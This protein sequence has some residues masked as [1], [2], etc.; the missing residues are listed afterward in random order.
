M[1]PLALIPTSARRA[2][3]RGA[4]ATLLASLLLIAGC[5]GGGGD[6]A[7]M[8]SADTTP[9]VYTLG[10]LTGF[11]SLIVNGVRFDDSQASITD[12]DGRQQALG[13]L[14]LGMR[15]EV[16]SGRVDATTASARALAV[17]FGGLVTGPVEAVDATAGTL[18]VLGQGIDV[19]STTVIDER[20]VG[21]LA[22]VQIGAVLH[23]HGLRDAASGRIAAT[24][25][26]PQ[27]GATVYKLR[28][29]VA[30]LDTT[31]KTL[32]IGAAVINYAGLTPPPAG[33]ADGVTLR[34]ALAPAPVAGQWLAQML[35][36]KPPR[37]T[38][39]GVAHVRGA[40]TTFS[41]TSSFSV[42]GLAVD[43]SAARFP[44]GRADLA[45][46]VQ[47]E[48][49][50]KLSNNLLVASEVS[51]EGKHRGEDD[52]RFELHGAISAVDTAART[53]VLRGVTVNYG[54]GVVYAGGSEAG[55]VV[56]AKVEVKG[57]LGSSRTLVQATK[58]KFES[59]S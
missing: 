16:D 38:D 24:R 48:V 12:D 3:R 36:P 51:V 26:E 43:A 59:A 1:N 57:G 9:S 32:R 44:D 42:E 20:L 22:A 13:A 30:A 53:F 39:M 56:G 4:A 54:V 33:L 5:G 2:S 31:A 6:A 11:G 27:P 40:I 10:T 34:L 8:T 25:I 14:R 7:L 46:G 41:S 35:G 49:R 55:L 21:G 18:T 15:V 37:P 29:T 50:G 58:I 52:R 17:R 28:G 45:L 19:A 47:V 23:V